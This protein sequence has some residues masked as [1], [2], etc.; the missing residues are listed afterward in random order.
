MYYKHRYNL[1]RFD[2]STSGT[3]YKL[4][5]KSLYDYVIV[6]EVT[7]SDVTVRSYFIA[8]KDLETSWSNRA[9]LTY[10]TDIKDRK[11]LNEGQDWL[12]AN[13][14]ISFTGLLDDYPG[15]VAAYSLRLLNSNYSGDAV[16][17]RRA[18]DNTTQ[19][20]GFIDGELD[21]GALN[22]F[23]SG[24]NGFVTTWFDQSGNGANAVNTTASGQPKIYDS[25]NGIELENNKPTI[26]WE[27]G[28]VQGL[29]AT[30]SQ[31]YAQPNTI[32]SVHNR[33]INNGYLFDG[34]DSTNRHLQYSN[35]L[36]APIDIS[37]AYPSSEMN[38]QNVLTA[39]FN[40]TNSESYINTELQASGNTGTNSLGGLTIGNR[41][42]LSNTNDTLQG[43]I[44]EITIYPTNETS[45]RAGIETNINNHYSIY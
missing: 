33:V 7:V 30:F 25:V 19:S 36:S 34:K 17:V 2:L 11:L 15:A 16:I 20:I 13:T 32:I 27:V 10:S 6:K 37:N 18:S 21:T 39:L 4:F 44:Q 24:T 8:A 12:A 38:K 14:G 31:V 45:N 3:A 9:S 5:I 26:R 23:C 22:T 35:L 1:I 28:Q 43:T 29:Q 42:N 40:T 41:F